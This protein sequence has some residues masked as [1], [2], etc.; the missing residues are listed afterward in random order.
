[1]TLFAAN[2]FFSPSKKKNNLLSLKKE[3]TEASASIGLHHTGYGP[4]SY[5]K[6]LQLTSLSPP[7]CIRTGRFGGRSEK[8]VISG[9]VLLTTEHPL[10]DQEPLKFDLQ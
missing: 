3:M 8:Y 2:F 7:T 1:M 4:T 9:L 5:Y 6:L 10:R